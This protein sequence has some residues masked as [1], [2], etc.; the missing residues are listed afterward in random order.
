MK[1]VH[2]PL[3]AILLIV[4]FLQFFDEVHSQTVTRGAYLQVGNQTSI[5]IRWRTNIATNSRVR[6]GAAYTASGLYATIIDD[7]A[8]VTEHIV[9]VAGLTPDT[10]YFYSIGSSSAVLQVSTANFFTTAPPPNT[11]RKIRIAAFGDCGREGTNG[12]TYQD[13]NYANY[14]AQLTARGIDAPDAWILLGDNAY[15]TGTDAEY[16]SNFFNIYGANILRNHK[17]FP[18]PG[19]HD[20][21]TSAEKPNRTKPYFTNFTVPQ[22]GECGGVASNRPN[23]YSFDIGNV[24]FLSLDSYGTEPSDV[25]SH[26]GSI[27]STTIMKNWIASDLAANTK[28]W[29][30]AYWH[31][32]PYTKADHNSDS[33]SDLQ[34][35]RQNFITFLEARGVDLIICGHSH[36]YERGYLMKN[37]TGNWTSFSTVTHAVSTSNARYGSGST[38]PYTYNS[39]P[40]NHGTVY[41]VEGSTGASGTPVS[42]FQANGFPFA[43]SD[44]GIFYLEIEDNRL[45]GKMLRQNGITFD[46]FTVVK[47]VN[48]TTNIDVVVGNTVS[49]N[50]SWPGNYNWNTTATT[51]SINVTP[52][53]IGTTNYTVTDNFGCITDQFSIN[54]TA[55]LPV[56][57]TAFDA[58]LKEKIVELTWSTSSESNND[59]FTIE[60]SANGRD[61]SAIGTVNGAGNSTEPKDYSFT[62]NNPFTGTNYYRLLQTDMDRHKKYLGVKRV[63]VERPGNFDVKTYAIKSN[64]LVLEINAGSD[65]AYQLLI[66]DIMGREKKREKF[67]VAQGITR[68]EVILT[69]G[70]YIWEVRKENS[71]HSIKQK[72]IVQ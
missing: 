32:P 29:T 41:V 64:A 55:T 25:S 65:G 9:T 19:N 45:D 59:Y 23:W 47:D 52:S 39:T 20:Y 35:I 36:G 11:T 27:S 63:E 71:G 4:L 43:V 50:A 7:A 5:K 48:K 56:S 14:Q 26:M 60:R 2:Q 61:Y 66:Y 70:A 58:K 68:K 54:A 37:F 24:H 33:E 34:A 42:G 38:C 22:A 46:S 30:I 10:K 28:K 67:N 17:L 53:T 51:R 18:S 72:V 12:A 69:P 57:L 21:G 15:N 1:K 62:D 6:L 16:T 3:R 8:S 40:L 49:L 44:A 13:N 31:H